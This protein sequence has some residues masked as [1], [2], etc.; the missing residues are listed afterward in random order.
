MPDL[1]DK[2][3]FFLNREGRWPDFQWSGLELKK[4]GSLELC[5]VPV[6]T[7]TLPDA[8][9]NAPTPDGPAGI[10]VDG[11]GTVYFSDP[12]GNC[13]R[14]ILGCDGNIV[15]IPC[16][17]GAGG[18][19]TAL[20]M[21]RGLFISPL[22]S[23]LFVAD[24]GNHRIVVFDLETFQL[25]E[26]WGQ[27]S[28][29]GA[30]QPGSAPGQFNTPWTL[31]MDSSGNAYIVDYGNQRVQK[32]NA[33]GDVV[34]TFWNN[35][36]A[37][38]LL[39]QPTDVAVWEQNS[40]TW[41]FVV[42]ASIPKIFIFDASGKPVPDSEGKPRTVSDGHLTRPMGIAVDGES[43]YVGDNTAQNVL[44]FQIGETF[45]YVGAAIGYQGPVAAL[46]LDGKQNLWVHPGGA[47]APVKLAANQGFG[48]SGSLWLCR[49]T[50]VEANG[51]KVVWH[52]LQALANLSSSAPTSVAHLEVFA[53]AAC[54]LAQA[55]AVDLTAEN[56]FADPK[57]QSISY[58][59][60]SDITDLYIGGAK[61]KYLWVG[62]QFS[63]DGTASPV[64]RQLRAEFDYPTYDT[65]L[66][67]VYRNQS[68]CNQFLLRLLSLL[69]SLFGGVEGEIRS[70]PKLFDPQAAPQ[71][72]LAWL[73]GCL[74]LD[75]DDNWDEQQQRNIIAKI[76][77]LSG[78][79]GTAKGLRQSL[80]LFAGVNAIVEEP[81]LN[82][83]W[84]S[85]P[86]AADTCCDTCASTSPQDSQNSILGWTTMLAPAQPQGAVVGTSTVLDQSHL[87]A[88]EDFGSPLF[89]DVAYQFCVELYRS[90]VMCPEAMPG[91]RAV[92]EQEK[93]AHTA[94][95]L[96]IIDP[97]FR[98]GFQSRVGI[99][100]V[101]AGPPRSLALGTGQALGVDSALAGP[102]PSLLGAESRL[103]VNTRLA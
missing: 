15:S 80:L 66:P 88:D 33:I 78:W 91:I 79:R 1:S 87:I 95:H 77:A 47:L 89:T 56:P 50:P 62:A 36:Q 54:D 16:M 21:P 93:P 49:K 20:N 23:S 3:Y 45:S 83:S 27:S 11:T 25:M 26:I 103:G 57:W 90:Q 19:P 67:A 81:I 71:K 100:T 70:I 40:T 55:P 42:D 86:S 22:R 41:I 52:R 5:S 60:N 7:T 24:S 38:G 4:D 61:A 76:F 96:C 32:F 64:L 82:A 48:T 14:R 35:V 98:V 9:K 84:W 63:G 73:A 13:V 17:G 74:G 101:V 10:A 2:N 34:P 44:R 97:S 68:D 8:V 69:E 94:Y 75:L 72:F 99:D 53:Y 46:R 92:I 43:L 31:S 12:E 59:P 102:M 85:L 30:P 29:S 18:G 58:L 39:H 37:S 6:L 28:L 65:Y 51:R